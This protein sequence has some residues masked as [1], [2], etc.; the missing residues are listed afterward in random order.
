MKLADASFLNDSSLADV[1]TDDE[2]RSILHQVEET[3]RRIE[4][5]FAATTFECRPTA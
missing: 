1:L 4:A 5:S 3:E 2:K